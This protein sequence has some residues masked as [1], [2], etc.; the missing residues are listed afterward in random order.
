MKGDP[1]RRGDLARSGAGILPGVATTTTDGLPVHLIDADT[2]SRMVEAGLLE[3]QHVEL[4][5]GIIADMSPQSPEH[6]AVIARLTGY[7]ARF[8]DRLRVQL[9][10]RVTAERSLPEPDLAVVT[11]PP[12]SREHPGEALLVIE[13]ATTSQQL[14]RVCKARLYAETGVPVYWV[15][16]LPGGKVEVRAQPTGGEY[17]ATWSYTAGDAVP[18]PID[19]LPALAVAELLAQDE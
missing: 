1:G 19:G 15:V 8:G 7:L 11:D 12:S 9:P 6:A 4:L 3:G 5:D 10:L 14:D 13:V 2:Y 16:D 18:A 17:T